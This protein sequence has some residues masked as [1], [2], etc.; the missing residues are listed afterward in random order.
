MPIFPY[1]LYL[2]LEIV[3]RGAR[4]QLAGRPGI[5]PC[6]NP[7]PHRV[8]VQVVCEST[9]SGREGGGKGEGCIGGERSLLAKSFKVLVILIAY[10]TYLHV[11][12]LCE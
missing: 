6:N 12:D 11:I 8:I 2:C 7:M 9:E 4:F 5:R 10:L 1:Y 3:H